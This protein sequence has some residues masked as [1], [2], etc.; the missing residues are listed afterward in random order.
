MKLAVYSLIALTLILSAC[1]AG[2]PKETSGIEP[3]A[4]LSVAPNWELSTIN[5]IYPSFEFKDETKE[6]QA[7]HKFI[8]S[9]VEANV[10]SETQIIEVQPQK[11]SSV[12]ENKDI[13][14]KKRIFTL[15]AYTAGVES[16]GK[17][18][19]DK[20][21]GITSSGT[22]VK[23]GRTAA[24]PKSYQSGTKIYIPSLKNT[25]TCEDTGSAITEGKL[26]IYFDDL[27][28]ALE[29]GRKEDVIG[30]VLNKDSD[31]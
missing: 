31:L 26:D 7:Y 3:K 14:G 6:K 16:T 29:F 8:A 11:L 19:G 15:T 9:S 21:Y 23:Q 10:K 1:G 27:D 4:I 5:L 20:G 30:Y 24:C 22:T 2:K 12:K 17:R 28:V 25:Y 13:D 18:K